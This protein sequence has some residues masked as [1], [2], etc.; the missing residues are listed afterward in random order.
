MVPGLV[1]IVVALLPFSER[2][3]I[4]TGYTGPNQ[5]GI[6]RQVAERLNMPFT[7]V[8]LEI[9]TQ[10]GNTAEGIRSTFGERRLLAVEDEIMEGVVL[11]RNTIIRINGS[12]LLHGDH[13]KRLSE[14]GPI[15]CLFATLDAVLQRLHLSMGARYH[16]PAE[17]DL[18]LGHIKREWAVRKL[19]GV[20]E[21][22]VTYLSE[23]S[24]VNSVIHLWQSLTM[25]RG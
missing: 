7:D 23:D 19:D 25:R 8:E 1:T 22:D 12:V 13:F 9:E 2:N 11:R 24:I 10:T 6:G 4:L 21:L 16:N 18:A 3:L 15:I 20:H 5:P 14:T 17:R